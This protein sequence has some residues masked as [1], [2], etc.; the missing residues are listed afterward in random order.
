MQTESHSPDI[1]IR[2][3]VQKDA[4]LLARLIRSSYATVAHRFDLTP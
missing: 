4:D 2:P 1:A 3:A